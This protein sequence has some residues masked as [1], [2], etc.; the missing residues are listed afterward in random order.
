MFIVAHEE[1]DGLS[2]L[3]VAPDLYQNLSVKETSCFSPCAHP[4]KPE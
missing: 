2:I 3:E 4:G 1:A